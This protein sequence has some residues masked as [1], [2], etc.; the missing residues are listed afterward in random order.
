MDPRTRP[1][2][3]VIGLVALF[4][5][6]LAGFGVYAQFKGMF[7]PKTQLRM[8][9]PRAGQVMDPGSKVTYNGVQ[10]GR[11]SRISEITYHG[12]P[13]AELVLD[14]T[15]EYIPGIPSNVLGTIKATTVF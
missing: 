13:A 12:R 10:V 9:A 6:M 11:V 2:F 5:I 4:V 3:K 1:A 14:V 8:I 7:I 15:P